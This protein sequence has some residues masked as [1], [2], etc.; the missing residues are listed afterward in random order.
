MLLTKGWKV[1]MEL[2]QIAGPGS[3]AV[4]AAAIVAYASSQEGN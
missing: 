3:A 1:I 4:I 2:P